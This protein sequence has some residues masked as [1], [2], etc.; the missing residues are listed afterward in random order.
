MDLDFTRL[1]CYSQT[2]KGVGGIVLASKGPSVAGDGKDARM[3]CKSRSVTGL[4]W[5]L[6]RAVWWDD[7]KKCVSVAVWGLLSGGSGLLEMGMLRCLC[8]SLL[9][10]RSLAG[11]MDFSGRV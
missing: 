1:C 3:K 8:F 7:I 11:V 4:G 2:A 10:R 6:R 9:A 5:A